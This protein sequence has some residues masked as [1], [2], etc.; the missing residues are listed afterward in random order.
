M[1]QRHCSELDANMAAT[2]SEMGSPVQH[3]FFTG[4]GG[5]PSPRSF[6]SHPHTPH[7]GPPQ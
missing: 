3:E 1:N 5:E 7:M 2:R 6:H 4:G